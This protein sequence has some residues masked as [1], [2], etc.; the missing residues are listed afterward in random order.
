MINSVEIP[1]DPF[2]TQKSKEKYPVS[3]GPKPKKKRSQS[4]LPRSFYIVSKFYWDAIHRLKE[5]RGYKDL[6]SVVNA[7]LD[8][9]RSR[10]SLGHE[11]MGPLKSICR[12]RRKETERAVP[13]KVDPGV[14]RD[15]SIIA[16]SNKRRGVT[17][18]FLFE[19][20]VDILLGVDRSVKQEE[21][22]YADA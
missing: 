12:R 15:I 8:K 10:Y 13:F 14:T 7:A 4:R 17:R 22:N 9:V 18:M 20:G 3:D 19:E 11:T 16:A 2:D 21:I 5:E 1:L 6:H